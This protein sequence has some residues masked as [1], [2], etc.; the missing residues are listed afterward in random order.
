MKSFYDHL[1][2]QGDLPLNYTP[3]GNLNL[4]EAFQVYRRGYQSRL[5]EILGDTFELVWKVLGD[6]LFFKLTSEFIKKNPSESYNLSNYSGA[7]IIFIGSHKLSQ[8]FPFLKDL[9]QL[10][11]EQ[12]E[13]FDAPMENGLEGGALLTLISDEDGRAAFVSSMRILTS[14]FRIFDIWNALS[15]DSIPPENWEQPQAVVLYRSEYQVLLKQIS[16][17]THLALKEIEM[18]KELIRSCENLEESELTSL[19]HFL[20]KY[21]LLKK[22]S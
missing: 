14:Q 11:W 13:V 15:S 7:F 20:A 17:K 22:R 10:C 19:F 4:K 12:K 16:T 9:A 1:I 18:G 8:E 21:R 2:D 3:A 5:T 6:D